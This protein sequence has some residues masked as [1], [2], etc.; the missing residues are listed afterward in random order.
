M[1]CVA[2]QLVSR[3]HAGIR[4]AVPFGYI[5]SAST[6]PAED[7]LLVKSF[8]WSAIEAVRLDGGSN[9]EFTER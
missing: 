1:R 7:E 9:A 5:E 2:R 8:K 6:F 4:G 3:F